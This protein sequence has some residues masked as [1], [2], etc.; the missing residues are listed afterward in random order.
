MKWLLI[1]PPIGVFYEAVVPPIGLG[2]LAAALRA[3]GHD[4]EILDINLWRWPQDEVRR[5]LAA[6][7]ADVFGI[8]GLISQY[9]YNREL[10]DLIKEIH[11]HCPVVQG[12]RMVL[13]YIQAS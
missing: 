9:T 3:A 12:G 4:V 13:T 6:S 11:P 1:N 8:T 10:A 5:R 2:Y 7:D